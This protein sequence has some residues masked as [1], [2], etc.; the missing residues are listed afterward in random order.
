MY[1]RIKNPLTNRYVNIN[2]ILGKNI[3]NNY[4]NTLNGGGPMTRSNSKRAPL[5]LPTRTFLGGSAAWE[6][7]S[8][9]P[10]R[11]RISQRKRCRRRWWCRWRS[12]RSRTTAAARM[13]PTART[14]GWRRPEER[15]RTTRPRAATPAPSSQSSGRPRR[16]RT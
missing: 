15:A 11:S 12:Q 8:R 13:L 4:I 2:S 16:P 10:Q 9:W 3:L 6:A 7:K 14:T 5:V 1:N